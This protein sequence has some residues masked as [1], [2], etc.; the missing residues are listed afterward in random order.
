MTRKQFVGAIG[1]AAALAVL[2]IFH[3]V[4]PRLLAGLALPRDD[5]SD[6]LA[7]AARWLVAPGA[8]LLA[9]VWAAARRGFYPDA[10]D[11][12]RTPANPALEI[13]LRYNQNTLEQLVLAAIA[14]A[15]LAVT[16]PI[17]SLYL[18]PAMAITFVIGRI[19]FWI[20][21]LI[22]PTG[23]AFGMVLTILPTI[24]AYAWLIGRAF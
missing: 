5:A 23:R 7:F 14:W 22:Y 8:T 2:L 21:Y 9:G 13:N 10:I 16:V 20:G 24:A 17:G 4:A 1:S 19:T 12:T 15:A 3:H 11:G 18:I 6:R